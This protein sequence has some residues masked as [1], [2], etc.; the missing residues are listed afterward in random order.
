MGEAKSYALKLLAKKDYFEKELRDKLSK[1]GFSEEEIEG[2]ISHL[3]NL[4]LIDDSKLLE[5]YI[6]LAVKKGKSGAYLRQKLYQK[7]IYDFEMDYNDE[8][9]SALNLL[10]SKYRKEKNYKDI[11]KF[12]KNRGFSY[13]VIQDAVNKF[14]NGEE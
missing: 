14:L 2:A 11:V 5:R 6:E 13:S 3:K 9:Q 12:L 7:G 8:L 1:K 10:H 4:G